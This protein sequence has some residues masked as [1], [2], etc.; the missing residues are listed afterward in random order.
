MNIC[1]ENKPVMIGKLPNY[2]NNAP[3][4]FESVGGKKKRTNKYAK[5]SARKSRKNRHNKSQKRNY[6]K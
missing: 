3:F 2:V 5:K 4:K 1:D 6:K